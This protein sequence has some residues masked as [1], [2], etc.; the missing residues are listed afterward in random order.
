MAIGLSL[1][2]IEH[3]L[4]KKHVYIIAII[5][6]MLQL[7]GIVIGVNIYRSLYNEQLLIQNDIKMI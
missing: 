3:C 2:P 5:H 4:N 1:Y 7:S 6:C